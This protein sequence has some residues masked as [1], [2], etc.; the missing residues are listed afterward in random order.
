MLPKT[1]RIRMFAGPNGSGKSTMINGL[2]SR[3]SKLFLNADNLERDLKATPILD[4]SQFDIRINAN[5]LVDYLTQA[6]RPLKNADGTLS[7]S[8]LL[9]VD[10]VI[11]G[12]LIDLSGNTIDSYLAARILDVIRKELLTLKVGFTFETV[13]SHESKIEFLRDAKTQGYRTYLYF[14]TTEDPDINVD[15]V[16]QRVKNGGHPVEEIKIRER[17]FR[18]M[19]MLIDAI[20]VSDRAYLFDNSSNATKN[21]ASY[22]CEVTNG[23]TL[24]INPDFKGEF[25]IWFE[26]YVLVH[27]V[28]EE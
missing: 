25:P 24:I 8:P 19:H 3:L 9:S 15:R 5:I 21:M 16:K 1:P 11:D 27:L 26:K 23:D 18:T 2:D 14:V 22:I 7:K 20:E 12:S 13:M 4:L 10:P 17:Y 28:D 6:S